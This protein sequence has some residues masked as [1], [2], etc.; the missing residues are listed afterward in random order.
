MNAYAAAARQLKAA[1]LAAVLI[2]HGA[3]AASTAALDGPTRLSVAALAGTRPPSAD[4]W[5][6][7]V[8]LVAGSS[9]R[10]VA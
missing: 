5:A 9:M 2:T 6:L 7:V 1:R 4:T 8:E 3:D 10:S